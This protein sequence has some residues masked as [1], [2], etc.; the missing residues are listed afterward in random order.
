MGLR[1]CL[2]SS[3]WTTLAEKQIPRRRPLFLLI[4]LPHTYIDITYNPTKHPQGSSASAAF[5]YLF[6][7]ANVSLGFPSYRQNPRLTMYPRYH[8]IRMLS[9]LTFM[10]TANAFTFPSFLDTPAEG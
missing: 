7:G 9:F 2:F 3:A 1:F 10:V 5:T 6:L 4:Y 8:K